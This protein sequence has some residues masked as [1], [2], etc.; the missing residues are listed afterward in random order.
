M[1]TAL[2]APLVLDHL[3][4]LCFYGTA[5]FHSS[6][7]PT[8]LAKLLP[9][10]LLLCI[11]FIYGLCQQVLED[12]TPFIPLPNWWRLSSSHITHAR[13][14]SH[15]P[16]RCWGRKSLFSNTVLSLVLKKLIELFCGAKKELKLDIQQWKWEWQHLF[17]FGMIS[18]L[19]LFIK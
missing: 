19:A 14:R 7:C 4:H 1:N 11:R 15:H 8:P 13:H 12:N 9:E 3:Q 5:I 6:V 18:R 2:I 17:G 16:R 10:V